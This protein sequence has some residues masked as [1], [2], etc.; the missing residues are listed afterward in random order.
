M[1]AIINGTCKKCQGTYH[2][3]LGN[4]KWFS[5]R[6]EHNR[7]NP[8]F[9][10]YEQ[11]RQSRLCPNC[12]KHHYARF[13]SA[14]KKHSTAPAEFSTDSQSTTKGVAKNVHPSG[15]RRSRQKA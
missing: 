15:K 13:A 14:W 3:D 7:D 5:D 1:S 10:S 8:I 11:L 9:D 12:G 6:M 4:T 2:I